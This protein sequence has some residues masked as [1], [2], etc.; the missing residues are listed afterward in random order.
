[1]PEGSTAYPNGKDAGVQKR[2]LLVADDDA[3]IRSLVA[4][5]LR[6]EYQV[7]EASNGLEVIGW[8]EIHPDPISLVIS[9]VQMPHASGLDVAR[10]LSDR[11][12]TVKLL[13]MSGEY[14]N[15]RIRAH[16]G[17]AEI[18]FLAKPFRL[19]ALTSTV[20]NL[21]SD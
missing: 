4:C 16:L 19:A 8:M 21:L 15:D 3:G 18:P 20:L 2:T 10:W 17:S 1:M 9:D 14:D 12:P 13:L 6:P 5:A 11:H 7:L